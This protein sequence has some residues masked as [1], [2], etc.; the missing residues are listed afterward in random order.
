MQVAKAELA[1]KNPRLLVSHTFGREELE[2]RQ[3]DYLGAFSVLFH[4]DDATAADCFEQVS[5]W[6]KH[7]STFYANIN[8]EQPSSQ[9][10][11]FPFVQ[12]PVAFYESLSGRY[13]LRMDVLG[14][15]KDLGYPLED[16]A[17]RNYVLGFHKR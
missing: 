9:W 15:H 1:H 16:A 3:F 8:V 14:Q 13:G 2:Q 11:E 5:R 6:M 12:R 4:F 7:D 17:R 10:H